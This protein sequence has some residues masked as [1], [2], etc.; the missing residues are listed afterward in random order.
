MCS[1]T[2]SKVCSRNGE[3]SKRRGTSSVA[4]IKS[5]HSLEREEDEDDPLEL[6]LDRLEEELDSVEEEEE[7]EILEILEELE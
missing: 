4:T 2:A 5:A 3:I 6:E 1:S 7:L